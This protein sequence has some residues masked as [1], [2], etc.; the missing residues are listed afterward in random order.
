M[1]IA[2]HTPRLLLRQWCDDDCVPFAA[3]S[4]DPDV[5]RHLL[6]FADRSASDRWIASMRTRCDGH[7]FAYLAVEIPGQGFI[8]AVGLNRVAH[9]DFPF[10]PAVEIGWRLARPYWG[11]GYAT[12]AAR[13]VLDD[14]F[15]RLQLAEI[16][17][18]TVPANGRSRR[19]MRRLGMRRDPADDFDHPAVPA[20]HA[21]RRHVLYRI[22]R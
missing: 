14:G 19:L 4:A 10:A 7:G 20:G 18:F 2:L 1:A 21:L 8:G 22:R 16:V 11:N 5:M 3:M 12:E 13:A 6:P 17:A 15:G 9:P